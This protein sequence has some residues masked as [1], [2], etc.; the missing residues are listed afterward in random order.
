MN[1]KIIT[2]INQY[3]TVKE[4]NVRFV[5]IQINIYCK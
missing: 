4:I 2:E 1:L 5:D 3:N